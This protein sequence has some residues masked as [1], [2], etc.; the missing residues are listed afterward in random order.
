MAVPKVKLK[1]NLAEMFGVDE[2]PESQALNAAIGQAIIDRIRERTESGVD[3]RN[4]AFKK[5]SKRYINSDEFEAFGKSASDVNLTLSGDMLGL[6]DVIR[7]TKNV[8]EIGWD[9]STNNAKAYNHIVG[10]TVPKR[11]F[12]GISK[13][14][15]K[16]IANEFS[17]EVKS[18]GD[19]RASANNEEFVNNAL[20]LIKQLRSKGG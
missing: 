4:Q 6:M 16:E 2:M 19:L 14:E 3:K 10:D 5:Y 15:L 18:F 8:I 20:N 13:T 17:D 9:D 7:S 11:D 12:F 1:I